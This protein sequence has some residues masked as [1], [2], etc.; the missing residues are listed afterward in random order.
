MTAVDKSGSYRGG[1]VLK[2]GG[3]IYDWDM[4]RAHVLKLAKN[5]VGEFAWEDVV[6]YLM[7]IVIVFFS[8]S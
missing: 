3:G 8:L 4:N 6:R 1:M 5:L 2:D 7:H